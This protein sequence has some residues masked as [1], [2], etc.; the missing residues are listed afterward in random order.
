MVLW[1]LVG[2]VSLCECEYGECASQPW[3]KMCS[4]VSDRIMV[5]ARDGLGHGKDNG[6]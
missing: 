3:I 5:F 4:A 1:E 6:V 2:W